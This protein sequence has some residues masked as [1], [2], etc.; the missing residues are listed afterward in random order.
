MNTGYLLINLGTPRSP[1]VRD[2]RRYLG[3]FL[4]DGY[5][6]DA[7]W[8]VRR[9][10]VS[11]FILPFRPK[12]SAAAYASIWTEEGSP[13]LLYSN[14]LAQQLARR[15]ASPVALGMRYGE[16]S[17]AAAVDELVRQQV[18]HIVITPMYPQHADSTVT[19]SIEAAR[20]AIPANVTN[21]VVAPFYA[22]PEHIDALCRRI[23]EHLPSDF[24]HLLFS[25]HGLPERHVT[26]ADP[27]AGHCLQSPDCCET[28]SAAHAT[29]YRHQ[30][31]ATSKLV[32]EALELPA[33][34][35]SI[36]FQSRLGRLPWLA[37]YTDQVLAELPARGIRRLAVVC[38]AFL[39]D[40]LETLEEIGIQ[41]RRTF[42]EAGGEELTLIPCLN[43]DAQWVRGF[44]A[45]LQRYTE[46]ANDETSA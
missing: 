19:T 31:F 38:P 46:P 28:P 9:L 25:Y 42:L 44:A 7:P 22:A 21:T 16:P 18:D 20:N 26:R 37:P 14:A 35:C 2:V 12:K 29:C 39:A 30:V 45:L 43:D 34:R 6:L 24:D 23:G 1:A 36:S 27:T 11:A 33:D 4:M 3:E 10:I 5:V 13:L 8:P 15:L 41:G 17:I 32:A 40:N